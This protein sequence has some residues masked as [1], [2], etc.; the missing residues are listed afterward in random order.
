MITAQPVGQTG[1]P[2]GQSVSF[3]VEVSGAPPIHFQWLLNGSPIP[4]ATKADYSIPSVNPTNAGI[5]TVLVG[6]TVGDV[7]SK[8]APLTLSMPGFDMADSLNRKR[9]PVISRQLS[10]AIIVAPRGHRASRFMP[11]EEPT[12]PSG[13]HG[14]R[15]KPASSR[16]STAGSAFDTVLAAYPGDD[17]LEARPGGCQR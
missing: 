12:P 2:P 5:Y 13:S 10:A 8:P 7:V 4:G 3:F 15:P 17:F 1:V 14:S 9:P 11:P 6:N 16:M